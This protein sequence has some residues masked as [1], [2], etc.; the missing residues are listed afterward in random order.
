MTTMTVR[1]RAWTGQPVREEH[2]SVESDGTVRVYDS[3]A[4]H[5]TTCHALGPS[6]EIRIRRMAAA[7]EKRL[8][9]LAAVQGRSSSF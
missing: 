6:A 1:C 5:Y 3:I 9:P 2:V 7:E 4:G 8:C